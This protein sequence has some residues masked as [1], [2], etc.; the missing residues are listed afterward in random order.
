M[1]FLGTQRDTLWS[2]IVMDS[3]MDSGGASQILHTN[4]HYLG[5]QC[6]HSLAIH[7]LSFFL[8]KKPPCVVHQV[9][10]ASQ[11]DIETANQSSILW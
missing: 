11:L 7:P 2:S 10:M 9:P 6:G 1:C 8:V 4:H 3:V 5:F